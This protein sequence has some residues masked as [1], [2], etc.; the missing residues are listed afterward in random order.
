MPLRQDPLDEL[1]IP[2][3]ATVEERDLVTAG[4]VL[5]GGQSSVEFGVRGRNVLGGERVSFGGGI[6]AAG[7]C[8]L[9]MW[10]SVDGSVLVGEDAYLGARVHVR[11]Q[12]VVAG[13]LDIGD[14]VAIDEGFEA[15][16]WIVIRNPMPT[17]VFLII[18]LSQLLRLGEE[19]AAEQLAGELF[20]AEPAEREPLVIPRGSQVGD[21]AWR[22]STP[23]RVGSGCRLHGNLR[24]QRVEVGAGTE[25]FGSLRAR[26]D[27]VVGEGS[28]IHGDATTRGGTVTIADGVRVLGDVACDDAVIH[29]G[30]E[31]DGLIR[32]RGELELV[33]ALPGEADED[34]AD[35]DAVDENVAH[36]EVAE[37]AAEAPTN[38]DVASVEAVDD[39]AVGGNGAGGER[40]VEAGADPVADGSGAAAD[41]GD[42]GGGGQTDGT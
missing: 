5:V 4:D 7:D 14:D 10:C 41:A 25:L 37:D 27:V 36:D 13:D 18:Y 2:D 30:A 8:R 3:G 17:I 23:A 6:E 11:G 31:I 33:S 1:V 39:A 29:R 34:D 21:D 32:A 42:V 40:P 26:G 38:G 15:N 9:D 12:L 16:G 35:E 22:V 28:T 19:E 24:A 20:D